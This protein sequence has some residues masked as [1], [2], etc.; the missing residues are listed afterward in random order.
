QRAADRGGGC[1]RNRDQV[2]ATALALAALEVAVGRRSAALSGSELVGVHAEAHRA[3]RPAPLGAGLGEDLVQALLH[4]LH[5]DPDR[6]R[7]D[8]QAGALGD[9]VALDDLRGQP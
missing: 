5:P 7:Y 2:R 6:T 4:G 9:L 8:E 3:S 1:Y